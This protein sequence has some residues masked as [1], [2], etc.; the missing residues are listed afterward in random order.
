MRGFSSELLIKKKLRSKEHY[1]IDYFTL[2]RVISIL[3]NL[4]R[5]QEVLVQIQEA[6]AYFA[7][8][9]SHLNLAIDLA[10]L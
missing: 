4:V 10:V 8:E 6:L 2:S 7:P 5:N 1:I 9:S 3:G